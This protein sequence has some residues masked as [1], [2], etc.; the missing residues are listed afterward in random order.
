L[1]NGKEFENAILDFF[2]AIMLSVQDLFRGFDVPDFLRTLL[3]GHG[4]QPIQII[5]ADGRLRRHRRHQFQALQLLDGLF[6]NFLRHASRVD[7][8]L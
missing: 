6:V 3:P 5:T 2:Q 1:A 8:L 7:F 4:Q